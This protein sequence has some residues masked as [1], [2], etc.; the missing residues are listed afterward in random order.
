MHLTPFLIFFWSFFA[1]GRIGRVRCLTRECHLFL[2]PVG[3]RALWL[4][5]IGAKGRRSS[6]DSQW[7]GGPSKGRL[8]RGKTPTVGN[9][10]W[11]KSPNELYLLRG[12][13]NVFGFFNWFGNAENEKFCDDVI[14]HLG[15]INKMKQITRNHTDR[16]VM[17]VETMKKIFHHVLTSSMSYKVLN[18]VS[19]LIKRYKVDP[20]KVCTLLNELSEEV[21]EMR[22]AEN[23]LALH[24]FFLEDESVA[25][26]SMMHIIDFFKSKR[27]LMEAQ[28]TI[29]KKIYE[30]CVND[31]IRKKVTKYKLFCERKGIPFH[32]GNAL[33]KIRLNEK[34]EDI[35]F[36]YNHEELLRVFIRKV[37]MEKGKGLGNEELEG[38][39]GGRSHV[40]D[41]DRL[42]SMEYP[43]T[44]HSA[45][46]GEGYIS[47]R[48]TDQSMNHQRV[49]NS[50]ERVADAEENEN[51][52]E[53]KKTY[54]EIQSF[55]DSIIKHIE[56]KQRFFY[57]DENETEF[58]Q[59]R[60]Q[61][62]G[63]KG[64]SKQ[65]GEYNKNDEDNND[66]DEEEEDMESI[67]KRIDNYIHEYTK[68]KNISMEQ[69]TNEFVQQAD[70][71]F[72]NFLEGLHLGEGVANVDEG[73]A[74]SVTAYNEMLNGGSVGTVGRD[75]KKDE[76]TTFKLKKMY[77]GDT[78]ESGF[79][80]TNDLL[81]E[82][83][84]MRMLYLLQKIEYL[85]FKYQHDIIN[86]R[87]PIEK[88][89]KTVLD[90]L[91]YGYK[92]VVSPDV[93]NSIFKKN[94][95]VQGGLTS[96]LYAN[97]MKGDPE[98]GEFPRGKKHVYDFKCREC[99]YHIFSTGENQFSEEIATC[100]QCHAES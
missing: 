96:N 61:A 78:N 34:E 17:E 57:F 43:A 53:L 38:N 30:Q 97:D 64:Q 32:L 65:G 51:L 55:N 77:E 41:V 16:N 42:G 79:H 50:A 81:Y 33:D 25:L 31:L 18:C 82:R 66:D 93:D 15:D 11:R 87:Y 76:L 72:K 100:P 20:S 94:Q 29:R 19:Y 89:E 7:I 13:K 24:I 1:H 67:Q 75:R 44:H 71:N 68:S 90:V 84:R 37:S 47:D 59:N 26:F 45:E 60:R 83:L 28:D 3:S 2:S 58:M 86:E 9:V 70:L 91:K 14:A 85:K 95:H 73:N 52:M 49:D 27:R 10:P 48:T 5:G 39:M 99:D 22:N 23:F 6:R 8:N 40:G 74:D 12:I 21:Q 56:S 80:L 92:I 46:Y 35:Y 36:S 62:K 54:E 98:E 4:G 88:N 69:F 63:V